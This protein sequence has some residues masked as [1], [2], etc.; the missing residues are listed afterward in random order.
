MNHSLFLDYLEQILPPKRPPTPV[1]MLAAKE[2]LLRFT[3]AELDRLMDAV[4]E[5]CK[6]YPATIAELAEAARIAGIQARRQSDSRP[7][8]WSETDCQLCAGSGLTAVW[9]QQSFDFRSDGSRQQT[10]Q[11][12]YVEP[13]QKSSAYWRRQDHDDVRTVWLC[14]CP[15]GAAETLPRGIPRWDSGKPSIIKR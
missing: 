6:F 8:E 7:H 11:I 10:L 9:W 3:D 12:H 2:W 13:Y 14:S 4:K 15:A 1:Q 5:N